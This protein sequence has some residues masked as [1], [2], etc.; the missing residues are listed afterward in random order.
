M[1]AVRHA[2]TTAQEGSNWPARRAGRARA[3]K[4]PKKNDHRR[5]A[6]RR[7]ELAISQHFVVRGGTQVRWRVG[8]HAHEDQR[9]GQR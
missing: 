5:A 8:G 9:V 7:H 4:Q 2:G 6:T 3:S 1:R